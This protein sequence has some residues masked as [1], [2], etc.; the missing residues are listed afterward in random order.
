MRLGSF[1][2]TCDVRE[3]DDPARG[4]CAEQAD[5][6]ARQTLPSLKARDR[7]TATRLERFI[8]ELQKNPGDDDRALLN[9]GELLVVSERT[10]GSEY[11][12]PAGSTYSTVRLVTRT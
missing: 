5:R 6:V 2:R 1:S 11:A 10:P 8:V 12:M 7:D 3:G 9:R 4:G